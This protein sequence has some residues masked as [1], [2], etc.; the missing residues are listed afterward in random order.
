MAGIEPRRKR[1]R[2]C[3]GRYRP[4]SEINVT[5]LVD[6]MLVLLVVFMV[7]APLLTVGVPVDLPQTQAPPITEPKEPLV[8]TINGEGHIFIQETEVPTESLVPRLQA[9]TG[10][11]PD[12][13]LYVRGDKAINYGR[14]LEVMSLVS[15]AG[16]RKVSLIAESPKGA[17]GKS[18]VRRSAA[19]PIGAGGQALRRAARSH[20]DER[21]DR[22]TGT[23]RR[24]RRVPDEMPD[25][26]RSA[27]HRVVGGA[28]RRSRHPLDF[29]SAEAVRPAAAGRN[30]DGGSAGDDRAGDPSDPAQSEPAATGCQA[31]GAGRRCAGD[32]SRS[33]TRAAS[34]DTGSAALGRGAAASARAAETAGAQAGA[35]TPA[36][37]A[38]AQAGTAKAG[39]EGRGAAG[40]EKSPSRHDKWPRTSRKPRKKSRRRR[41][42]IPAVRGVAEEPGAAARLHRRPTH[43][44]RSRASRRPG[45]L[46]A[47]GAAGQPAYGERT[48]HGPPA[49]RAVLERAGGR[50]RRQGSRRRDQGRRRSGRHGPPGDDRRSGPPAATRSIRAAAESARRAFFNPQCRPLHLPAEKYAIWKDLVVDFSPKD[51]L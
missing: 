11:N 30:A 23:D 5:P 38:R 32:R 20:A 21:G 12:A 35:A 10:N 45:L 39:R 43:R 6:V 24:S 19:R 2:A 37:A 34:P 4:M 28:A 31:G 3:A 18:R 46:A 17:S 25:G 40:R 7:A 48:R 36:K 26:C 49:D 14:V 47:Q 27:R 33:Q 8:I 42:T 22:R 9:I 50:P 13:L 16:F 51:I 41:N 44:R 1:P 15:S 29:R